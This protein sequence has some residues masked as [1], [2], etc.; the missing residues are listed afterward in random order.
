MTTY[1]HY[2]VYS[3]EAGGLRKVLYRSYEFESIDRIYDYLLSFYN[4][5][6]LVFR[7][8]PLNQYC[9]QKYSDPNEAEIVQ[10][11]KLIKSP[12]SNKYIIDNT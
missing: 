10:V 12:D 11:F 7:I 9:I 6:K 5:D 4:R 8:K 1:P 2:K 3:V